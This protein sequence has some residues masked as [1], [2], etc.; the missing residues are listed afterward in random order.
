MGRGGGGERG[1]WGEWM[2][3]RDERRE[4]RERGS[5]ER[6]S[7]ERGSGERREMGCWLV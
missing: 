1:G 5:G 7:G 6:G 2:L 4:V 3:A